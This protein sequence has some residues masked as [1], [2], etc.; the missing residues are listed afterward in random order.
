MAKKTREQIKAKL[1]AKIREEMEKKKRLREVF[2]AD[3]STTVWR[4]I[5]EISKSFFLN[6]NQIVHNQGDITKEAIQYLRETLK[7][8]GVEPEIETTKEFEITPEM[9][10][11]AEQVAKRDAI[12][13]GKLP[14]EALDGDLYYER[15]LLKNPEKEIGK[16]PKKPLFKPR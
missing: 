14:G 12:I 16:N 8:E 15:V 13:E 3:D 6:Q 11:G 5:V 1:A 10:K 9:R 2:K 7:R 4:E